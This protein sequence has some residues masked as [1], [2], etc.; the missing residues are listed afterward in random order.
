MSIEFTC[1]K[2]V[3]NVDLGLV[4][5]KMTLSL[6]SL[7]LCYTQRY[8]TLPNPTLFPHPS[9]RFQSHPNVGFGLR[10]QKCCRHLDSRECDVG[11]P[12]C[13]RKYVAHVWFD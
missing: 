3:Q 1:E 8:F 10:N 7:H 11:E 5:I 6:Y 4:K 12:K 2:H 9:Y 13:P